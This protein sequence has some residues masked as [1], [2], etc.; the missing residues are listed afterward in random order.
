[1]RAG[2]GR[3]VHEGRPRP[4]GEGGRSPPSPD[5]PVRGSCSA[6]GRGDAH[7]GSG[8][9]S[10]WTGGAS[11]HCGHPLAQSPGPTGP[12]PRLPRGARGSCRPSRRRREGAQGTET[13]RARCRG[14]PRGGA[15]RQAARSGAGTG[16]SP[17][18]TPRTRSP[19]LSGCRT[20]GAGR[21][22]R[23]SGL[24]P[25]DRRTLGTGHAVRAPDADLQ[26]SGLTSPVPGLGAHL[27]RSRGAGLS[28]PA[29]ALRASWHRPLSGRRTG[30][31]HRAAR[32][33]CCR[34]PPRPQSLG[35]P[36]GGRARRR[37]GR[38]GS[39]TAPRRSRRCPHRAGPR[40]AGRRRSSS[41]VLSGGA[42]EVGAAGAPRTV[43]DELP[44]EAGAPR[45]VVDELPLEAGTSA[46]E[47][48]EPP[49]RRRGLRTAEGGLRTA[50]GT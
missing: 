1:M 9:P 35:T 43:V 33:A 10:G 31:D 39:R 32:A 8:T 25:R 34:S 23:H 4:V 3:S 37:T 20:S 47:T 5:G 26:G 36:S 45:T 24:R 50:E 11:P 38:G 42:A 40:T 48:P 46:G 2:L 14:R 49:P 18:G 30:A 13:G 7:S 22:V 15:V 21:P 44:L 6:S 17:S 41:G 19:G 27:P 12:G 29:C 28:A 16:C